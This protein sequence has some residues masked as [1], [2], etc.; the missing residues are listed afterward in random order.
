MDKTLQTMV[1]ATDSFFRA[2]VTVV[3]DAGKMVFFAHTAVPITATMIFASEKIFLLGETMFPV[4]KR[5]VSGFDTMVFVSHP[6]VSVTE[7]MV[8]VSSTMVGDDD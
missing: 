6:K 7:T 1:G 5:M 2:A 3:S 8:N 4:A